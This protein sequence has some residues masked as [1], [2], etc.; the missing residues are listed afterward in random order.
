[1]AKNVR[2]RALYEDYLDVNRNVDAPDHVEG[3][4]YLAGIQQYYLGEYIMR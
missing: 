2:K 4:L 1:M 3:Y